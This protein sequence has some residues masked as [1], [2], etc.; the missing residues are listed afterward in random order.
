MSEE[1]WIVIPNWGRFQHYQKRAGEQVTRPDWIK[2]YGRLLH[3]DAYLKLTLRQRGILHGIWLL[4][5]SSGQQL[6]ASVAQLGRLLG[7]DTV[8]TRDLEALSDAGFIAFS[9]R[10]GLDGLYTN[11]SPEQYK[12]EKEQATK[13]SN[14]S[15]DL[16]EDHPEGEGDSAYALVLLLAAVEGSDAV[17]AQ[18]RSQV[19]AMALAPFA[20]HSARDELAK[21]KASGKHIRS[22]KAY[23]LAILERYVEP[24]LETKDA[25]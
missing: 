16:P 8:R 1:R 18:L 4:Y 15:V 21:A 14:G 10:D 13:L 2:N 3:D 7:E 19:E 23:V 17:K 20:L 22:D 12:E 25:A 6:G 11:S 9:S 5:A 24:D